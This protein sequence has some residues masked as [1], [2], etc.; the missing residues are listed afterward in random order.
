LR[1][2]D[3]NDALAHVTQVYVVKEV[4]VNAQNEPELE[5]TEKV[6]ERIRNRIEREET[7]LEENDHK[8]TEF[9]LNRSALAGKN[10]F[11][12]ASLSRAVRRLRGRGIDPALDQRERRSLW[13]PIFLIWRPRSKLTGNYRLNLAKEA[14]V[15]TFKAAYALGRK[16]APEFALERIKVRVVSGFQPGL[17]I[18]LS[19]PHSSSGQRSSPTTARG[20]RVFRV[21]FDSDVNSLRF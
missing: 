8:A 18:G 15:L 21:L 19:L 12:A 14:D 16:V 17:A 6:L 5:L 1:D 11:S 4:S 10:K 13:N 3:L 2:V 20:L 9:R 7:S